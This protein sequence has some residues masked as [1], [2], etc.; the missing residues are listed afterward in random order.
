M[1]MKLKK[2]EWKGVEWVSLFQDRDKWWAVLNI[3]T[4]L[5]I[6]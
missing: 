5:R 4:N 6:P 3:V 2:I 1:K